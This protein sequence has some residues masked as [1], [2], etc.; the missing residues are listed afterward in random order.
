M[1]TYDRWSLNTVLIDT[2][3]TVG[4]ITIEV[5]NSL[6]DRVGQQS[7]IDSIYIINRVKY[8]MFFQLLVRPL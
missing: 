8:Y 2:K 1:V 3:C 6:L 4:G 7:K 5:T